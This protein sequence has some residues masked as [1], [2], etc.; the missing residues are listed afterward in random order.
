MEEIQLLWAHD[1]RMLPGTVAKKHTHDYFHLID[2][3]QGQM[4]FYLEDTAF[5]LKEGDMILVCR[6][7]PHS[8]A[9]EMATDLYFREVKFSVYGQLLPQFLQAA[10]PGVVRDPFARKLVENLVEE[11]AQDLALKEDAALASLT[12]LALYLTAPSRSKSRQEPGVIDTTGFNK[13][14]VRVIRYLC[15]HYGEDLSLDD[16][17]AGVGVTKNYLCNAFKLNTNIT[18]ID[19]LNMIRIR[20][21]AEQIIYSDLPL[22]QVAQMCGYVSASHFNRVFMRYVGMPPGQCR[23]AYAYDISDNDSRNG[24]TFIG[25]V[26]AGKPITREVIRDFEQR[27]DE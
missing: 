1:S 18:I 5:C 19:C 27:K 22:S 26:L 8:F 25:C 20:K 4:Q 7:K 21:A 3:T 6:G 17:S 2:V 10:E 15:D 24:N 11:Y 14:S 23:R 12:A 16:I 9:N 13:L